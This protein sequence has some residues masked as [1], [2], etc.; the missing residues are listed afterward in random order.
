MPIKKNKI[1][2]WSDSFKTYGCNPK[3]IAEYILANHKNEFDIVWVID[4]CLPIPAGIPSDIRIVKYFSKEYLRELHTAH[5]VICNARTNSSYMWH[6][7]KGQIYIQTWHSSLRLK[8]IEKDAENFLPDDYIGS[9]KE[10]SE[11]IDYIIS[12][13]KFSSDIFANS[14]WY[15]GKIL[16]CGTPRIDYLLNSPQS[17]KLYKKIGISQEYKYI[18]Y[19]PTFRNKEYNYNLDFK[20]I[21]SAAQRAYGG[22]WKILYR[23]HPN[24]IFKIKEYDLGDECINVCGYSDMQEL[25]A[26]CDMLITDYSSCMFDMM[27]TKKPC[28][29]YMPDYDDY[30]SHERRL[31]FDI[32][33]LPFGKAYDDNSLLSVIEGLNDEK[34][35]KDIAD[36]KNAIGSFE[37]GTA[38]KTIV[39]GIIFGKDI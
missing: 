38:C 30:V 29:L 19:A 12:G 11:R 5:F 18:L 3:Y 4:A 21:I 27:Y 9:S 37:Q 33:K 35:L 7:R 26:V 6:K 13:C 20:K 24:L 15:S 32:E 31:Y 23:L 1:I 8:T 10:D 25:V 14:F 2:M 17:E 28:I 39:D 22:K 36:F 34:Y 16:E